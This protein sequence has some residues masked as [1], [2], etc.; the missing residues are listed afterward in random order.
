MDKKMTDEKIT[1]V[2]DAL[3]TRATGAG[4]DQPKAAEVLLS[5]L[6]WLDEK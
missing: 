6:Q 1:A 3:Y 2:I 4:S 5:W